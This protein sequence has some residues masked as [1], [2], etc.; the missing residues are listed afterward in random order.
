MNQAPT[1]NFTLSRPEW[2]L[3][4]SITL[5]VVAFHFYFWRQVG[6]LWRDEVNSLNIAQVASLSDMTRDSFPV[7]MPLV[8]RGWV[9]LRLD[10]TDL[11]L[12][13]LGLLIGLGIVGALW[14]ASW[15]TRQSPPWFGLVLFGMNSVLIIF[16]D[17]IR[18]YGLGCLTIVLAAGATLRFLQHPGWWRFA[19][20]ALTCVAAVQSLYHNAV[21]VGA[22][23]AGAVAVCLRWKMWRACV[24]IFLAGA[25]A[26]ASL[27]PYR[28][29]LM[30]Q[31]LSTAVLKTGLNPERFLD[32]LIDTFGFP[33]PQYL[34][35]WAVLGLA[36]LILGAMALR[37]DRSQQGNFEADLRLFAAVTLICGG[38]GFCLFLWL[39][40][41]PSQSWY[42]LPPMA[43]AAICVDAA[44][45][46]LTGRRGAAFFG[47]LAA[48]ALIAVPISKQN[49]AFHFTNVDVE[50][51]RLSQE[52][53]PNDYIVVVP[54]YCGIS[55]AHY[56][57]GATQWDTLPPVADHSTHRYDLVRQQIQDTNAI[58]P[59]L[60]RMAAT[61]KSGHR[62]WVL[63]DS[64]W[65]GIPDA[66]TAAA[67][68]LPPAPLAAS[69]WS[70][71]PY[72]LVWVS[73]TAHF[74][75]DHSRLRAVDDKP[76]GEHTAECTGLYLAE[77][78]KD[79]R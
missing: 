41:M 64:G 75:A 74:L 36:V 52:A 26:A 76:P 40:A 58:A 79:H 57:N 39:A 63:A 12:R 13:T 53:G 54:W 24:Q 77:G 17:S 11:M 27:W 25:L 51:H 65:M 15:K 1:R 67:P 56:F 32:G 30:P 62:V 22:L 33:V 23:C 50:A 66:G 59:V 60:E 70:E 71:K 7:L 37:P 42:W 61:L 48:S 35:V 72:T 18:P 38:A 9:A 20:L 2:W 21:L 31:N 8:I 43:V 44:W 28:A 55:F 78:W 19:W 69:G 4:I 34:Y 6:G 29:I 49:L 10:Q 73:Q 16:G 14:L 68:S 3:A 45:P 5:L 47:L 46:R